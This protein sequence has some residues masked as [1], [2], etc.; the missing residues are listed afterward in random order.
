MAIDEIVVFGSEFKCGTL[1]YL[2]PNT[3]W[4]TL[5]HT[6]FQSQKLLN[7]ESYMHHSLVEH[8]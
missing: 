6:M 5:D 8:L 1:F 3:S 4:I 2:D 7:I